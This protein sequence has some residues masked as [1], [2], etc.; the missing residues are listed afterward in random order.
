MKF[1]IGKTYYTRF[2][3]DYDSVLSMTVLART[4]KTITAQ[5]DTFGVKK[6]RVDTRWSD[7]ETVAPLGRYSMAPSIRA[8]KLQ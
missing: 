6:L 7:V 8:D 5:V 2:A 3:C 4:E 1:E